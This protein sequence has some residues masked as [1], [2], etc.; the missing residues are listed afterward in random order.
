[1]DIKNNNDNYGIDDAITKRI[2]T[3]YSVPPQWKYF[4]DTRTQLIGP[5]TTSNDPRKEGWKT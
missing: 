3:N 1:M 2:E 4:I 5:A